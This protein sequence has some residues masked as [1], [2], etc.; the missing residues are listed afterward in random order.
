M[1]VLPTMMSNAIPQPVFNSLRKAGK[2]L[3][4]LSVICLATSEIVAAGN[5]KVIAAINQSYHDEQAKFNQQI[6]AEA[7]KCEQQGLADLALG[8]VMY[9]GVTQRILTT[10]IEGFDDPQKIMSLLAD[11]QQLKVYI[12]VSK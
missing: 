1:T 2:I 11:P 6:E 4:F 7:Q 3:T 10:P 5:S 9:P 8:E 12:K